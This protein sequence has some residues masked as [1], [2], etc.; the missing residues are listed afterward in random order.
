MAR[1]RYLPREAGGRER[2]GVSVWTVL[3]LCCCLTQA[4]RGQTKPSVALVLHD[5]GRATTPVD[6]D[7]QFRAGDDLSWASPH[8][9]DSAWQRIEVGKTWEEQGHPNLTGFAWYRRR[10]ELA[11]GSPTNYKL[12]LYLPGVDSACEIYWNGVKVGSYGKVPPN[13]V[14]YN[15]TWTSGKVVE[16][17]PAQ[18]GE[19][20][21]RVWKAP[22]VFLND[23]VEGGL[24]A[25]PQVGSTQAV[26]GL[27]IDNRYRHMAQS[28]L[29]LV[30][31]CF[32]AI[33]GAL[34]LLVWLR[35]R[36]QTMLLW[37]S[38]AM[39][40]LAARYFAFDVQGS[41]P[42]RVGYGLVGPL[43]SLTVLAIWFLLIDLLGLRDRNRL[44]R[45]TW[46]I[47]LTS[48]GLDMINTGCQFFD[49]TAWPPNRFLIIDV[50]VT[51]PAIYMELWG[52]VLVFSAF[53]KRL[54]AA[55]W[56]LAIAALLSELVLAVGDIAGLGR[57][58]THWTIADWV[59]APVLTIVG[60]PLNAPAIVNMLL[61]ISILY[62]AWRYSVE[63]SRRQ[64]ALEQEM[65]NA[66][67]VQQVLIPD[68]G[69]SVP[70]FA[71][72]SVYQPAGEVAGDFFQILPTKDGGVL[73]V[74]G[75][76]SGKGM[77]AALTVSLLV[78]TVRTLAHYTESPGEILAAMNQ[79]LLARSQGGFTTC[80]VLR[81]DCA[82]NVTAANAGHLAP[83]LNGEER[84]IEGGLPL[85]LA[86]IST[87]DEC[88]FR[89]E[90]K[91]QMTLLTDGVVEARSES[92]EL[93]GFQRTQAISE[94]TAQQIADAAKEFGQDDDITVLT[95]SRVS[96]ADAESRLLP[97]QLAG[98]IQAS[99]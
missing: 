45:W 22:I 39:I 97:H 32:S 85:G 30:V 33:A 20:A 59:E 60:N 15:F 55:R 95:L 70:G 27:S 40:L 44:V 34:A 19:L 46:I 21:L 3:L 58:W 23:P 1:A 29:S 16:L 54:D 91:Q 77:P 92:G 47:G 28:Q 65:R 96:A 11:S 86:A 31:A 43:N 2:S 73:A 63:H 82:G 48:F 80:L 93:F 81:I 5:L 57:R 6:G 17:G 88:T 75:D 18:S 62:V 56:M 49:W 68:E 12:G 71:I 94:H 79:R 76:V 72:E 38:L 35:G 7:W 51:I 41:L 78:G 90:A 69:T 67:A 26:A 50:A 61:L 9:D 14:W 25:M 98:Q 4:G 89:L 52:L 99:S 13:P 24:N 84:A 53:G 8:Y 37:L 74:I 42:F 64:N 36:R 66:R 10:L 83:Y 87:Y